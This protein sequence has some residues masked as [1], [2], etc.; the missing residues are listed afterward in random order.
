MTSCCHDQVAR[1]ALLTAAKGHLARGDAAAAAAQL[2]AE[3]LASPRWGRGWL[4]LGQCRARLGDD[5]G[6]AVAF[7]RAGDGANADASLALATVARENAQLCASRFLP[8]HFLAWLHDD[9]RTAAW[10]DLLRAALRDETARSSV[11]CAGATA[12]SSVLHAALAL[13]VGAKTA[14]AV[15]GSQLIAGRTSAAALDA[16][17]SVVAAV[18]SPAA[19]TTL[20]YDLGNCLSTATLAGITAA[21][22]ACVGIP[23]TVPSCVRVCAAVVECKAL[24]E[25]NT[26]LGVRVK[27]PDEEECHVFELKKFASTSA[28]AVRPVQLQHLRPWRILSRACTLLTLEL[29]ALDS[30][31]PT[32]GAWVSAEAVLDGDGHA[33]VTWLEIEDGALCTAPPELTGANASSW[34]ALSHVHGVQYATFAAAPWCI[35]AGGALSLR[36]VITADGVRVELQ[37]HRTVAAHATAASIPDY[38]FSMLN[39]S[40]RNDA[41]YRGI[42]AAVA[43]HRARHGGAPPRVLDIGCGAGLLSMFALHAG[44]AEVVACERDAKLAAVACADLEAAHLGGGTVTVVAAHSRDLSRDNV[45]EFD[46]IVSEVFGS[47]ALS[48]GALPTLAHARAALLAPG[49]VMVPQQVIICGTLVSAALGDTSLADTLEARVARAY[50]GL[51]PSR[52]SVHA[53]DVATLQQLTGVAKFAVDLDARLVTHGSVR[54]TATATQDGDADA[55]LAWFK[56]CFLGGASVATGPGDGRRLHWPQTL[57]RLPGKRRVAA[58]EVVALTLQFVGDRTYFTASESK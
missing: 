48:E 16:R 44:A 28:R 30:G 42:V 1:D 47:D 37:Q 29:G 39:D 7:L 45:G 14:T 15:C 26:L 49:G 43:A 24:L 18:P 2:D 55:V 11:L 10:R 20:A 12:A 57:F 58:G 38:H 6:A 32:V 22:A 9:A 17:L 27:P 40:A 3:L 4:L 51:A 25:L 33:V 31:S 41:Y 13:S 36:G 23:T 5:D 53:P 34:S 8:R 21:R 46:I 50:D 19:H 56:V 52:Y 35:A 54:A